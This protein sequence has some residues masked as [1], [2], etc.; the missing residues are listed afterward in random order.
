VD[1]VRIERT[2]MLEACHGQAIYAHSYQLLHPNLVHR[3]GFEPTLE[4]RLSGGRT[5]LHYTYDAKL[6]AAKGL[7]PLWQLVYDAQG[8]CLLHHC[9]ILGPCFI[10]TVTFLPILQ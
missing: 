10:R 3:A 6:G 5:T 8:T 2:F 4:T 9:K 1:A 7:E